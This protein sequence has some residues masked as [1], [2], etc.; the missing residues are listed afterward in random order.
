MGLQGELPQ[1]SIY[2]YDTQIIGLHSQG[3]DY[4]TGLGKWNPR[5]NG[6]T[7]ANRN[8]GRTTTYIKLRFTTHR[9]IGLHPTPTVLLRPGSRL[10]YGSGKVESQ[11]PMDLQLLMRLQGELPHT[12]IYDYDTRII[13]LHS[14]GRNYVTGL[15]RWNPRSDGFTIANGNTGRTTTYIELRFTTHIQP[16]PYYY[17]RG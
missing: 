6:F 10:H 4:V 3:R 16:R 2:D 7:I 14:Q 15:G 13:G 5:S 11:I 8:T 17:G 1:T 12:S 9:I